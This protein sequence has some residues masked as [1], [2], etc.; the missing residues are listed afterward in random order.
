[1]ATAFCVSY[2]L[3]KMGQR[4]QELHA[5]LKRSDKWWH[6]L[7]STWMV[8]TDE[9][10]GQLAA[11]LRTKM[12]ANDSLLCIEVRRNMGGWLERKAWDWINENV[13]F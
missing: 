2:D 6:Y 4:Y 3:N 10:A 11:R 12:D 7:D 9:T 1:M 8:V 5:E 13:P